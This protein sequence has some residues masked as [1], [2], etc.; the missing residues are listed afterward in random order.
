MRIVIYSSR[1]Y[2]DIG[3]LETIAQLLATGFSKE[4]HEVVLL[5][6]LRPNEIADDSQF[7]FKV[8]RNP[9]FLQKYRLAK[10]ADIILHNS[11]SLKLFLIDFIFLKKIVVVHHTWYNGLDFKSWVLGKLKLS[12]SRLVSNVFISKAIQYHVNSRG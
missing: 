10:K 2:P 8:V 11:I 4:G 12:V 1:F 6:P 9:S 7:L 5:T 3:G